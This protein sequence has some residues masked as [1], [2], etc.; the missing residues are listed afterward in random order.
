MSRNRTR[1]AVLGIMAGLLA[2][3][4]AKAEKPLRIGTTAGPIGQTLAFAADLARKRGQ[5]VEIVEFTDWVT[6]NEAVT[7]G[8]LDANL[9]QHVPFL[10]STIKARGYRLLPVAGA[11]VLPVGLFSKRV[12]RLDAVPDGASVAIANDPVNA[13]RGLH[14]L[15]KAGLLKLNPGS[16]DD[17]SVADIV[18]NPKGLRILELDAAQLPRALDDVTL[19]QVSFTYLFAS[20]GDPSTALITDGSGNKHYTVSFVARPENR[21]EPRLAAFIA[22]FRS[23]EVKA[24]IETTFRGF[25]E[26]VW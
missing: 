24:Y 21:D 1:R 10:Q 18:A 17:A 15:E 7:D 8:S 9:F 25:F 4:P 11:F 12:T 3:A 13:A 5:A 22:T 16:G 19:A 26:P 20:G 6:P 2:A 14:L 23:P